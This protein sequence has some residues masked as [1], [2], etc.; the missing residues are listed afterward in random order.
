MMGRAVTE[1]GRT[2]K[3][4]SVTLDSISIVAANGIIICHMAAIVVEI[5]ARSMVL[6]VTFTNTEVLPFLDMTSMRCNAS[7]DGTTHLECYKNHMFKSC[8]NE[9]QIEHQIG[10][11][12]GYVLLVG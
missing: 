9:H 2:P 11:G 12:G 6:L 3:V 5:R 10:G 7:V 8:K 4:I 1:M